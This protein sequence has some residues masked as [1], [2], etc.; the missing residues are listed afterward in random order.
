[1]SHARIIDDLI[2][3]G[4]ALTFDGPRVLLVGESLP[5]ALKADLRAHK[6]GIVAEWDRRLVAPEA[7]YR[8]RPGGAVPMSG[9][10]VRRITPALRQALLAYVQRQPAA[11][12][13]WVAERATAYAAAETIGAECDWRAAVD[14]LAWQRSTTDGTAALAWLETLEESAAWARAKQTTPEEIKA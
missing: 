11:V 9:L 14:V 6:A 4:G 5:D 7:R 12:R 10:D 8:R 2:A 1:M 3:A 13:E